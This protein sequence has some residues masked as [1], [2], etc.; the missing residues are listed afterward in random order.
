MTFTFI[1]SSLEDCYF[2]FRKGLWQN[3]PDRWTFRHVAWIAVVFPHPTALERGV[4]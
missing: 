2:D 1:V 3:R 4:W